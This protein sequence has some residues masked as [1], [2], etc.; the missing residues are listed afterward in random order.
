M[1]KAGVFAGLCS[2]C[3]RFYFPRAALFSYDTI[4]A[5]MRRA[6][7]E[8]ARRRAKQIAYNTEHG[9]TPK[10]IQKKVYDTLVISR[11]EEEPPERLT[12]YQKR[13]RIAILTEQMQQ[14]ARE[15]EFETAAK[16]R[17]AILALKG[18]KPQTRKS[19]LKPGQIGAHKRARE[20]THK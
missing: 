16:L 19:D 8:T 3:I 17:D 2:V 13:E 18:E 14:A 5:S 1:T 15:L 20:K 11:H 9:I 4:T 12:E 7:D 6:M 10:T